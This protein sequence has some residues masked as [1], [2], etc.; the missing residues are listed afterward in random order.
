MLAGCGM[1]SALDARG[2]V[3]VAIALHVVLLGMAVSTYMSNLQLDF[4]GEQFF[5]L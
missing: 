2:W 5:F 4:F 1:I 3:R